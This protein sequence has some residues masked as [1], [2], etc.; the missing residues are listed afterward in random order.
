MNPRKKK[1]QLELASRFLF[2]GLTFMLTFMSYL[3]EL[4]SVIQSSLGLYDL[5]IIDGSIFTSLIIVSLLYV[6]SKLK[7]AL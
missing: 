5:G 7:I 4:R 2:L 3:F 6:F 1:N